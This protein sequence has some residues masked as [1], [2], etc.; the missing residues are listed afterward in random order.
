M[1]ELSKLA[2]APSVDLVLVT[3]S[4]GM[5]LTA[6]DVND[7]TVSESAYWPD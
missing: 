4:K 2:T 7:D 1:A 5:T 6:S 3:K